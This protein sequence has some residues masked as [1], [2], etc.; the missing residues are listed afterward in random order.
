M[1]S[2][3]TAP[4]L[5]KHGSYDDPDVEGCYNGSLS[6]EGLL[7]LDNLLTSWSIRCSKATYLC[8]LCGLF[9]LAEPVNPTTGAL[10]PPSRQLIYTWIVEAWD[11]VL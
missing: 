10:Y 9:A 8:K 7:L 11:R 1:I 3:V 2:D 6:K 4:K 5:S